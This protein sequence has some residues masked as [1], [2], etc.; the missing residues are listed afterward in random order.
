MPK[1]FGLTYELTHIDENGNK[2]IIEPPFTIEFDIIRNDFSSNNLGSIR[3]YNLS[4]E[5]RN[6][7]RKDQRQFDII[8]SVI[9]KAGYEGQTSEIMNMTISRAW[10]IR[11]GNN[12][13]T[14][15]QCTDGGT[16]TINSYIDKTFPSGTD[17]RDVL[18]QIG[19]SLQDQRIALGA[20][21][22]QYAG[23]KLTRANAYSGST[24]ELLNQI[25]GGASFIDNSVLHILKDNE[26]ILEQTLVINA[27]TGLLGTPIREFQYVNFEMLF[28]PRVNVGRLIK[29]ESETGDL[30]INTLY[31]VKS[32]THRGMISEAVASPCYTTVGCYPGTFVGVELETQS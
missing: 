31:V 13:I 14:Q 27:E 22:N 2:T 7:I 18:I 11:E 10:S 25:S 17:Q 12:F 26:N 24:L 8:Q 4:K 28:E 30:D 23:Q 1:K 6:R 16:A 5:N 29:L 9:L 3:I 15:I 32:L 21:S 20:V 19:R